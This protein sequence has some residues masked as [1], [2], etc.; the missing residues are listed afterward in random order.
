MQNSLLNYRVIGNGYPVLF[1]HGFLESET[2]W[3][4]LDL[5]NLDFQSILIDLPG[6]GKS[7]NTDDG[8]PSIEFMTS[9][10]KE[11]IEFLAI[12]NFSV[13]GHSMGG[14]VALSLKEMFSKA[15]D[16]GSRQ[17]EK[18][19]LLN[20]NFWEDS[21][22][23]KSDRLRVADIVSKNRLLF[24][25][26]AIP[27]LFVSKDAC[28]DQ[29]IHLI[30]EASRID[31]HAIIYATLAMR[32]RADKTPLI[33]KY[34]EDFLVV[35]GVLDSIIPMNIM[36]Q[37]TNGIPVHFKCLENVGHMAHIESAAKVKEILADFL[38]G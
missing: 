11:L 20:S 38:I 33:A 3:D 34:P 30:E 31:K 16:K 23:K 15:K 17:C 29:I 8:E 19:V 24:I 1:L 7:L 5:G 13:V 18:V 28:N 6:H 35:Q 10:V 22:S 9:K 4:Y 21:D 12:S 25:R 27:N 32:K 26:E 36:M 14:Y 2:M 37:K